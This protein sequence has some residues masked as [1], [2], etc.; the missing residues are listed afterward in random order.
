MR[1]SN[2]KSG[3]LSATEVPFLG[4]TLGGVRSENE[5]GFPEVENPPATRKNIVFLNGKPKKN[6]VKDHEFSQRT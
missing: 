4:A 2:A 6:S 3:C 5:N 1:S